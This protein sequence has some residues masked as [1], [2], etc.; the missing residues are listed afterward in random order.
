MQYRTLRQKCNIEASLKPQEDAL[1]LTDRLQQVIEVSLVH[2]FVA[3]A[4][5]LG[6]AVLVVVAG[7]VVLEDWV[8]ELSGAEPV[9]AVLSLVT[10]SRSLATSNGVEEVDAAFSISAGVA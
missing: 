7:L 10:N 6:L 8:V 9:H 2:A 1:L 4:V 3:S 5:F